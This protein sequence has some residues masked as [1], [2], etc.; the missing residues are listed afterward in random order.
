MVELREDKVLERFSLYSGEAEEEAARWEL[1]KALC[2]ECRAWVEGQ[3]A[4][5]AGHSPG[6]LESLAAAEAFYQLALIDGALAPE[7]VS[8][9]ELKLEMG[10]RE[11]RAKQLAMEKRQ[12]CRGL[13]REQGFYFGSV[14]A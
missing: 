4:E 8:A 13:L 7:S 1:C 2:G 10:R 6:L 14:K 3:A 12:A 5:G 9:P 11:E